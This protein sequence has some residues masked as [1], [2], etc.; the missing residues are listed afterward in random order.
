[1]TEN[2]NHIDFEREFFKNKSIN[3]SKS[4][5]DVWAD[6]ELKLIDTKE[7]K[8]I[9]VDFR[10]ILKYSAAA[11]LIIGL[12]LITFM[13]LYSV[14]VQCPNGQHSK[15]ALPDGSIA[16]LN[17]NSE[18]LYHPYWWQFSRNLDFRGEAFFEVKKGKKFLV[19][20]EMASTTVLGTSFNIY[21]RNNVYR[22]NCLSGKV[23]V[24]NKNN[25]STIITKNEYTILNQE[26]KWTKLSDSTNTSNSIA[27]INNEFVFTKLPLKDVYEEIERQ[28]DIIIEGKENLKGLSTFNSKRGSSAEE[29]INLIGKPFGV[30]CVKI[31][32]KKY[33]L[34]QN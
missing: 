8:V 24:E 14:N 3:Y 7:N 22:V 20:S 9:H 10:K 21:A 13:R 1:M 27:W 4:K 18:I 31:S 30:Y 2:N 15:V 16:T 11:V 34:E 26:N 33:I 29:M 6:M 32:D 12:G 19:R 17:A 28:F 25:E 5:A 23:L